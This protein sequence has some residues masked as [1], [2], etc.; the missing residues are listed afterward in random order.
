M[1]RIITICLILLIQFKILGQNEKTISNALKNIDIERIDSIAKILNYKGGDVIKVFAKFTVNKNGE[2]KD[3]K[4]RGPHILFEE[5]AI[6]VV[7]SI[8]KLD[9]KKFKNGMKEMKFTLPINFIIETER[10][11]KS[12][13]KKENR[14][15]EKELR[16]AKKR[17]KNN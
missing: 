9:P 5:E 14:K 17:K 12:R 13:L 10:E 8:P 11:R 7:Y 3:V 15:K 1:K 16:K 6:R 2:I 4:A